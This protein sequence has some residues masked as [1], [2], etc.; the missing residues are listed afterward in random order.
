MK[1][2]SQDSIEIA[3][4]IPNFV[5]SL[6]SQDNDYQRAQGV[7]AKEAATRVGVNVEI[8][9]SGGDG[10]EQSR[11]LLEV[12][13]P[14]SGAPHVNGIVLQPAGTGLQQVARAAAVARIGWVVLHKQVDYI[15]EL[16]RTY[17]VPAFV[18]S[19]D[20]EEEGRIQGRQI[21]ALLPPDK[22][23]LYVMGPSMDS[24]SD[25]RLQGLKSTAPPNLQMLTIRG[26][27]TEQSGYDAISSWLRLSTSQQQHI[28][29]IASQNDAMAI[30]ARR[31]VAGLSDTVLRDRLLGLPFLG[32]DGLPE[33]GQACVKRGLL[34][35]T[36]VLPLLAGLGVEMLAKA[37][38]TGTE[39]AEHTVIT[40]V[41]Y[42][43]L[44][45]IAQPGGLAPA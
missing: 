2:A 4:T 38:Q 21:A 22:S 9:F 42:P 20:H 25:K 33:S 1:P 19:S 24:I 44:D 43:A 40:P 41:S 14:S 17:R 8:I 32:C 27:W 18:I 39:P 5:V 29:I 34:A 6:V 31:A 30:G 15:A 28:G 11:Q 3:M 10:I 7:A 36:V 13:Q 12:I 35:A 45:R 23:V 16:R 37:I 26:K